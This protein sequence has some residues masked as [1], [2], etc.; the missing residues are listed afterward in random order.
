MEEVRRECV[1]LTFGALSSAVIALF[2]SNYKLVILLLCLMAIDTLFGHLRAVKDKKWK[3]YNARWGLIGKLVE[4]VLISLMY[5]CEWT[6]GINWL[7]NVVVVYFAICEGASIA[8][9]IVKG[10]L[11]SNVPT[12]TLDFL[13]RMKLN[14]LTKFKEWIRDFFGGDGG[15]T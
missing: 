10:Q 13:E 5:M 4:L 6:F 12:E 9:N 7:V 2:G 15:E 1:K 8:E 14:F 3:S 11:N